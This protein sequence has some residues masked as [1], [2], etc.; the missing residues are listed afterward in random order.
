MLRPLKRPVLVGALVLVAGCASVI[1]LGDFEI[2]NDDDAGVDG[3]TDTNVTAP[4]SADAAEEPVVLPPVTCVADAG[5]CDS[6]ALDGGWR[7]VAVA[8]GNAVCPDGFGEATVTRG[9]AVGGAGACD[10][11]VGATTPPTNCADAAASTMSFLDGDSGTTCIVPSQG[12]F[13]NS[14]ACVS[15]V[16]NFGFE[17]AA[18]VPATATGATCTTKYVTDPT[19]VTTSEVTLCPPIGVCS[20]AVCA[21]Q[22]LGALRSCIVA[23]GDLPCPTTGFTDK[24]PIGAAVETVTCSGC[25]C[26]V[27]SQ[28]C[29]GSVEIYTAKDCSGTPLIEIEAGACTEVAHAAFQ[30]Y[31]YTA[32]PTVTGALDGGATVAAV[33]FGGARTLCCAP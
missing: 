22:T 16:S 3:A 29:G 30:S 26:V 19:K 9:N 7:P 4:P 33:T 23:D 21:R 11:Q 12:K 10:C 17:F 18:L 31:R 20:E 2:T 27:A 5:T 32:V 8:N 6:L 1:G 25:A 15:G 13:T 28:K 14:T 24:I